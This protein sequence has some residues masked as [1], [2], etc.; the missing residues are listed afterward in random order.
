MIFVP[1]ATFEDAT[2]EEQ[3]SRLCDD[4]HR[5]FWLK[6]RYTSSLPTTDL[7]IIDEFFLSI[8]HQLIGTIEFIE[9]LKM[10]WQTCAW[11]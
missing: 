11:S 7:Y 1:A 3:K 6:G 9:Q 5:E 8:E 10:L 2:G 4:T